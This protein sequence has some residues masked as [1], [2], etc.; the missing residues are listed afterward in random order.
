MKLCFGIPNRMV[1][2]EING[3]GH[4]TDLDGQ[5]ENSSNNS[6]SEEIEK[7]MEV[8]RSIGFEIEGCHNIVH[9]GSSL[10]Y[11]RNTEGYVVGHTDL[12]SISLKEFESLLAKT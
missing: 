1:E 8:G 7:I 10:L 3:V 12:I 4:S 11:G 5:I 2:Q 9:V 6:H